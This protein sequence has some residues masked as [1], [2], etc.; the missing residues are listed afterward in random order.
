MED[1][2]R[3][4]SWTEISPVLERQQCT[5]DANRREIIRKT[6]SRTSSAAKGTVLFEG[7]W[8]GHLYLTVS[9]H[10]MSVCRDC[11]QPSKEQRDRI[12]RQNCDVHAAAWHNVLLL[13]AN[14]L[15]YAV[16]I[17]MPRKIRI[18]R[19][20]S[21]VRCVEIRDG[22]EIVYGLGWRQDDY[23]NRFRS[24]IAQI[25]RRTFNDVQ[26]RVV[27]E[28]LSTQSESVACKLTCPFLTGTLS[29]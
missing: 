3:F 23:N 11:P 26:K 19:S 8:R 20:F 18:K 1:G 6:S 28:Y 21:Y 7:T 25:K 13:I 10:S 9:H 2:N 24:G 29:R 4:G 27:L 16:I 5:R 12:N 22:D 14:R 17:Q 15:G